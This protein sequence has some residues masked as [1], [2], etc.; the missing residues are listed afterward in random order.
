MVKVQYEL[1]HIVTN[2][3]RCHKHHSFNANQSILAP[4][5]LCPEIVRNVKDTFLALRT[6]TISSAILIRIEPG[7]FLLSN[8]DISFTKQ[9]RTT[10][11]LIFYLLFL[12]SENTALF[13]PKCNGSPYY[14]VFFF[15]QIDMFL[16]LTKFSLYLSCGGITVVA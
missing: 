1:F 5:A 15:K 9:L 12:T 14:E 3:I 11:F 10:I 16:K 7:F 4:K 2:N 13:R 8:G 6:N